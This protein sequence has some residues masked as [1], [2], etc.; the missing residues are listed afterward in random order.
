M[1]TDPEIQLWADIVKAQ[2]PVITEDVDEKDILTNM[3]SSI[4]WFINGKGD[5][6]LKDEEWMNY[7]KNDLNAAV[8]KNLWS[9]TPEDKKM[10]EKM[11]NKDNEGDEE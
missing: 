11:N 7:L 1:K 8:R 6:I 2:T 5:K 10:L 4:L 3:F 9:P